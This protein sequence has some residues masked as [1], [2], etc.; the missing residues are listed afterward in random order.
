MFRG[1]F[2]ATVGITTTLLAMPSINADRR[3][4]VANRQVRKVERESIK[5]MP[6]TQRPNR[7]GHFYGN[8]V[9]RL[10]YGKFFTNRYR[11]VTGPLGF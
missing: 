4:V 11:R 1:L 7:P 10:H 5:Q 6:L 8:N 3:A 2:I 9:R